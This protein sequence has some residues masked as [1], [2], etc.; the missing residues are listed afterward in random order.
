[1]IRVHEKHQLFVNSRSN[2]QPQLQPGALDGP[3]ACGYPDHGAGL[4]QPGRLRT[5]VSLDGQFRRSPGLEL[6]CQ[7]HAA[8]LLPPTAAH[9]PALGLRSGNHHRGAT[10]RLLPVRQAQEAVETKSIRQARAAA[11]MFFVNLSGHDDWTVFSPIV[12]QRPKPTACASNCIRE[13]RSNSASPLQPCPL[14]SARGVAR[15]A[16][17]AVNPPKWSFAWLQAC[18]PPTPY[19]EPATSLAA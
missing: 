7:S 2:Q 6:R 12:I 10:A 13:K 16:P 14:K 18:A 17:S 4:R 9:S 1:M 8:L 3:V 11:T 5:S 19:P 15:L